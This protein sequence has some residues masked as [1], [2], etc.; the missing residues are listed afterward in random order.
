[1]SN[2]QN[3]NDE[4]TEQMRTKF[5]AMAV[6]PRKTWGKQYSKSRKPYGKSRKHGAQWHNNNHTQIRTNIPKHIHTAN[7]PHNEK[8]WDEAQQTVR[9]HDDREV[10]IA[11]YIDIYRDTVGEWFERRVGHNGEY[12]DLTMEQE[13]DAYSIFH[14][15]IRKYIFTDRSGRLYFKIVLN[16]INKLDWDIYCDMRQKDWQKLVP[17]AEYVREECDKDGVLMYIQY[18]FDKFIAEIHPDLKEICTW[19][20]QD[21]V[22]QGPASNRYITWKCWINDEMNATNL[23]CRIIPLITGFNK[24]IDYIAVRMRSE[25]EF[26]NSEMDEKQ[27]LQQILQELP[28]GWTNPVDGKTY[29]AVA[30]P[31]REL[32]DRVLIIK[33]LELHLV[34]YNYT[35]LFVTGLTDR[36]ND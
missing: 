27:D 25:Y 14:P 11:E 6:P 2:N 20:R 18:A 12:F 31:A 13:E 4:K 23:L 15:T 26:E 33:E 24:L 36:L 17:D 16:G 1:M 32:W 29:D 7:K 8:E 21:M 9:W 22:L 28:I 19:N 34:Y 3:I 10:V 30:V 5:D 35:T